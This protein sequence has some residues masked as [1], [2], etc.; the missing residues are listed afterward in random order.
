M[1]RLTM[2]RPRPVPR[3]LVEKYGKEE[4]LLQLLGNAVAGVGNGDFEQASRLAT[5]EVEI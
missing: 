2:A 5:S 4:S 1:M 3:F